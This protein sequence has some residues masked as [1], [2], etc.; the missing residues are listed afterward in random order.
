MRLL[1]QWARTSPA[2]ASRSRPVLK[3]WRRTAS[4]VATA[5]ATSVMGSTAARVSTSQRDTGSRGR[6]LGGLV[7]RSTSTQ[8]ENR[9]WVGRTSAPDG[10]SEPGS[11]R[12]RR[13][14]GRSPAA[15]YRAVPGATSQRAP[16]GPGRMP[17]ASESRGRFGDR[18]THRRPTMAPDTTDKALGRA[19][20]RR[21]GR[22]ERHRPGH[23]RVPGR[24]RR[25]RGARGPHPSRPWTS[26][27]R[28]SPPRAAAA[29]AH[30][31]DVRDVAEA[32]ALVDEAVSSTGRL[33]VMV[34]NAGVSYPGTIVDADPEHWRIMLE[35]NVLALLVGSQA[36]VRAMRAC[37]AERPHREHLVGG[38]AQPRLGRL[39]RHQA[40]RELHQRVPAPRAAGRAHQG[41]DDHARRHRHEL[42]P[43]LRP[44]RARA[45]GE[46]DGRGRRPA[47]FTPGDRLSD[48]VL[49]SA[50]QSMA[51]HLCA[52]EDVAEAVLW[53]ITRPGRRAPGRR[54]WCGPRRT[55]TCSA[56]AGG[57]RRGGATSDP[58]LG[59]RRAG[60][61][62]G[63]RAAGAPRRGPR[64]RCGCQERIQ[65]V[66]VG[67]LDAHQGG[68]ELPVVLLHVL[69][70]H[71]VVARRRGTRRGT[72]AARRGAGGSSTMK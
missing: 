44:R 58:P 25:P 5:P 42:R 17:T 11:R 55:S 62:G 9:P 4:S 22:L 72:G 52:P 30:V 59:I 40:R 20:R 46:L 68:A 61:T 3:P 65:V 1:A 69:E 29:E 54:S 37:S 38:V 13:A 43:Q 51:E 8:A 12:G 14:D 33:D 28:A 50:Q 34:N 36:A 60:G 27:W 26:R 66:A 35:T 47:Q 23:R 2:K 64:R 49:A 71:D 41:G 70:Q 57:A 10:R 67:Q 7:V 19:H 6:P 63:C 21:H 45:H 15:S 56:P 32:R 16:E 39:R 18:S 31:H 53:A 24:R 48:E